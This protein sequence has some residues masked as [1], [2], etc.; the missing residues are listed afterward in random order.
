MKAITILCVAAAAM[1]VAVAVNQF[2]SYKSRHRR[3]QAVNSLEAAANPAPAASEPQKG[4]PGET[5]SPSVASLVGKPAPDFNL[6]SF[7]G[8]K[9]IKLSDYKGRPVIITFWATY[10]GWCREEA[11][12]FSA[13]Q[14]KYEDAKLQVLSVVP[15][16][17]SRRDE[18]A[19]ALKTWG[20]KY[21]VLIS[22]PAA[23]NSYYVNWFPTTIYINP[24]GT[25]VKA[26]DV[27]V[28][29]LSMLEENVQQMLR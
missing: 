8:S 17:S 19:H 14:S 26:E 1:F 29:G 20:I 23:E 27:S 9:T 6:V 22:D 5:S 13:V 18:V 12:W 7:D 25:I 21:P 28:K 24:Q 3:P 15:L 16:S 2:D 4:Q 10:C 11:P